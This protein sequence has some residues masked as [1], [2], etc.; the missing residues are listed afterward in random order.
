LRALKVDKGK[1][2]RDAVV[3]LL[4]GAQQRKDDLVGVGLE[5]RLQRIAVA[6]AHVQ[7]ADAVLRRAFVR[8]RHQRH[9]G[10]VAAHRL[11]RV[12]ALL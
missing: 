5:Q 6:A 9:A 12:F 10:D 11:E 3:D 2:G 7:Q 8:R 1:L 4:G